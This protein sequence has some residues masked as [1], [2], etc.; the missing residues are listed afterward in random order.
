MQRGY[1]KPLDQCSLADVSTV[2]GKCASLGELHRA[3]LPG[4]P[5]FAV[6]VKTYRDFVVRTG[7]EERIRE[8]LQKALDAS[9]GNGGVPFHEV[10]AAIDE[11]FR[12]AQPTEEAR[13][14]IVDSY[15]ALC[16][17]CGCDDVLVAVRSSATSEDSDLSSFAGQH[18]TFLNVCGD[19]DVVEKTIA[20]WKSLFSAAALHYRSSADIDHLE[21]EMAVAVQKMVD[22]KVS[23]VMFTVN[24]ISKDANQMVIEMAWGL[25][26]GVVGGY[27][28][29]DNYVVDKQTLT[30]IERM[31]SP[32]MV[33]F[34]RDVESGGTIMRDVEEE[35]Q[36][37]PC[38]TDDEVV[39]LARMGLAIEMYY[40]KPM[41]IEWAVDA[42]LPWPEALVTLQSRPITTLR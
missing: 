18:E 22:A 23:G 13:A 41:D 39:E 40:G 21:A 5:G 25:G 38:M 20:C 27:V 33:E 26:E 31:I 17:Q 8:V 35:R 32:K 3:G 12:G 16:D 4:S 11:V 24:P 30:V 7:I 10:E 37:I 6:T 2:G 29:P 14:S 15:R 36:S 1:I 28:A 42:Q 19:D 9:A 34:V